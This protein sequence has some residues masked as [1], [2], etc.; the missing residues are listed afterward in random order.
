MDRIINC[1]RGCVVPHNFLIEDVVDEEWIAADNSDD[2]MDNTGP[3]RVTKASNTPDC[4]GR[5]ELCHHPSE[6]Q[7]TTIN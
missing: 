2:C 5:D 7:D 3:E 6:S 4:S 1:V